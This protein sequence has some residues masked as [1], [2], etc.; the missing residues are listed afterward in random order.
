MTDPTQDVVA[1]GYDAVYDAMPRSDTLRRIW[2][3][4]ALGPGYP[5]GFEHI[6]FLTLDEMRHM[7]AALRL[8]RSAHLVDLACG[9]GGPGLWIARE[10]GA[11]LTGIDLS[12]VAVAKATE[13][14]EAL[15]LSESARFAIG[16][17][18]E[19][20]LDDASAD[21]AMSVDALQ[22]APDKAAAFREVARILRPGGRLAFTAF[23][24]DAARVAGVPVLAV[25]PVADY[26]AALFSAGFDVD[27]YEETDGWRDH[28]TG[29][30]GAINA[31]RET[32]IEEM[33]ERA[34]NSL[35]VETTLTIERQ[36]Y[37]R[38][39]F[40]SATRRG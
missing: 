28:L 10:A 32:L 29:A 11:R 34:A 3:E 5:Q 20:G 37:R 38:R 6:S 4:H 9:A 30:Y 31:A 35:L 2:R 26:S 24:L 33:G 18:A 22:Y 23:E 36:P 1:S 40:V 25:D 17:F 13:R 21:A 12:A 39:V 19:T 27:L 8:E 16:S 15:G 14:A 7:A